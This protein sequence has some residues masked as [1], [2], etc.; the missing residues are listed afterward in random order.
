[1]NLTGGVPTHY[2]HRDRSNA[3]RAL[4]NNVTPIL[5]QHG[6]VAT[7]DDTCREHTLKL[8]TCKACAI[9]GPINTGACY[10]FFVAVFEF[11]GLMYD[12][13]FNIG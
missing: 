9:R 2:S 1:M 6:N 3:R 10:P 13:F 8:V 12:L 4:A 11:Y 5:P 7:L